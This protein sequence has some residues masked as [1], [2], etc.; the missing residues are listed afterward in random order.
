MR[1]VSKIV[2]PGR[3]KENQVAPTQGSNLEATLATT[4]DEATTSILPPSIPKAVNMN[5]TLYEK[6]VLLVNNSNRVKKHMNLDKQ[7]HREVPDYLS[8]VSSDEDEDA[9]PN[10]VSFELQP[11]APLPAPVPE[12]V[13]TTHITGRSPSG[14]QDADALQFPSLNVP[15]VPGTA[16]LNPPGMT[17]ENATCLGPRL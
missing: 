3:S 13:L 12:L 10:L 8:V 5:V 6:F 2:M 4:P 1:T 17:G 7:A 15:H 11:H 9:I 14:I 16:P